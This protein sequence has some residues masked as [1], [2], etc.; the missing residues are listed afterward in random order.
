ML[1]FRMAKIGGC[2]QDAN[3][4]ILYPYYKKKGKK[5][6]L[7]IMGLYIFSHLHKRAG[8]EYSKFFTVGNGGFQAEVWSGCDVHI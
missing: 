6:K 4:F 8:K 7:I 2:L 3:V 5:L 1:Y